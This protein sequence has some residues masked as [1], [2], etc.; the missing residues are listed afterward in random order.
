M[1]TALATAM[2]LALF[3][4]AAFSAPPER[5]QAATTP[6]PA[7]PSA[8]PS[9][10]WTLNWRYRHEAVSDA[11]F[12]RDAQADTLRLR[13]T[14]T[15]PFGPRWSAQVEAEGVAEL[16]DRFN[17]GANGRTQF[18]VV[19]DARALEIN[20]AWIEH[21][22][23]AA[24]VRIG[25]QMLVLDNSRFIGNGAWRQ[26]SQSFDALQVR[27]KPAS[28]I[29]VQAI[30]LDRVHR[31]AGDRARNPLA[32]ERDL[33]A[34]L[35]RIAWTLPNGSLVGYGYWI[36]DE[37]VPQASTR[38][39]GLRW[40]HHWPLAGGWQAGLALERAQ[41]T[42]WADA[43]GG[44]TAYAAIE[45]RLE[46]GPLA[47]RAGWQRLGA[48]RDRSFQTP[49]ASLHGFQG[50]ADQ[51]LATPAGGLED[52]W[53]SLQTGSTLLGWPARWEVRVHH[54]QSDAG[55]DYGNEWN[56]A[57]T[58]TPASGWSTMLK[59]ADYQADGFGRDVRKLWLQLE[60]SL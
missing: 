12:A 43:R 13:A 14:W 50:W 7:A 25:R 31:F 30:H 38:S 48:G 19:A 21:R 16:G 54:F 45:P 58:L 60:W 18:P 33:N 47:L 55:L 1:R 41:Q 6:S 37:D 17:S 9:K 44:S 46:R 2:A 59:Y 42:P 26:N 52:R 29:E 51:F 20:Q 56:A 15:Q 49:L 3:P 57:L 4:A 32:R 53:L 8:A 39:L 23:A 35:A 28:G 40:D 27:W 22:G 24:S 10:P 11:G 5:S 36:E 34:P